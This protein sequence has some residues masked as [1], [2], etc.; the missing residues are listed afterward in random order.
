MHRLGAGVALTWIVGAGFQDDGVEFEEALLVG[1]LFP[2]LRQRG[3]ILAVAAHANFIKHFAQAVQIARRLARPFRWQIAGSAHER[4]RGIDTG[5]QADVGELGNAAH[6]DDVRRLDIAMDKA[7]G[8]QMFERGGQRQ[9]DAQAF[10]ERQSAVL[11]SSLLS[12]R[13]AYCAKA[14]G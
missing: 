7:V 9:A 2:I 4:A 6:E 8:V 1:E 13:G 10:I 14:E 3:K 12:V 11:G 5:H